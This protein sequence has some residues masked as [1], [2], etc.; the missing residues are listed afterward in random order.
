MSESTRFRREDFTPGQ[1]SEFVP[2]AGYD[3]TDIVT[4][5]TELATWDEAVIDQFTTV[6][7]GLNAHVVN[8]DH[9]YDLL[10][11]DKKVIVY[12]VN[13]RAN[14]DDLFDDWGVGHHREDIVQIMRE[15]TERRSDLTI[16]WPVVVR[17]TP[18]FC[19]GEVHMINYIYQ[20]KTEMNHISDWGRTLLDHT[21]AFVARVE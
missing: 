4:E 15:V 18:S 21:P 7:R 8:L 10:H 2:D 12:D 20:K 6:Q 5:E 14:V 11:E 13:D 1:L 17:K 16:D 3:G 19:T 9:G